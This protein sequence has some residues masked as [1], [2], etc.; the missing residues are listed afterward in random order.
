MFSRKAKVNVNRSSI[1]KKFYGV[2]ISED[3][4]LNNRVMMFMLI[5]CCILICSTLNFYIPGINNDIFIINGL[6]YLP[7]IPGEPALLG[8]L[9]FALSPL[10]PLN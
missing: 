6:I 10:A 9:E 4:L 7:L 8:K 1:L 2:L 3:R 5:I